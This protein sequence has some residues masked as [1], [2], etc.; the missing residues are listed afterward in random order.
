[1]LRILAFCLCLGQAAQADPPSVAVDI[2]P[3]HALVARVMQGV[4][5][6]DLIVPQDASPHGYAL[7]PSQA[8]ALQ[9]ADLVVWM[10]PGLSPWLS[11][12]LSTLAPDARHLDLMQARGTHVLPFRE[13]AAFG[14]HDHGHDHEHDH[15]GEGVDPHAWLDPD[16]AALWLGVVAEALAGLDPDNAALYRA[17]AA[18]GQAEMA[19]HSAKIAARLARLKGVRFIVAHDSLHYFE[20]SF[21]VHAA[22]AVSN[23]DAAAPGAAR[24]VQLR[25]RMQ[26]RAITCVLVEPQANTD[27]LKAMFGDT[28]RIGTVDP[29]GRILPAGPSLYP[30]L[31]DSIAD[32]IAQCATP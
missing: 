14:A 10:G 31:L 15:E 1:M 21:G 23:S 6:A 28:L 29:L 24:L 4:G 30:A 7:R 13:G 9:G 5:G 17:N 18:E 11:D 20:A 8:R 12:A 32:G 2:A 16:N 19:A 3:V 25:Q 27:R 22:G 26:D